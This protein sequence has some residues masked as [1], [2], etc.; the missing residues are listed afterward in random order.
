MCSTEAD[1][2]G[3]LRRLYER[4]LPSTQKVRI[5]D[6]VRIADGWETEVYSF[7]VEYEEAVR[8]SRLDL[9]LRI[10]PGD[11]A[12][13]KSAREFKAMRQLFQVGFPV[14][15]VLLLE[16]EG[17]HLGKPYVI[18]EKIEGR[19]MGDVIDESPD[20]RKMEL[21]TQ[22]CGMFV[23]LHTLD[24]RPF[25]PDP[26]LYETRELSAIFGAEL[27]GWRAYLHRFQ[28]EA[29]DPVF[30]WLGEQ[31]VG[32]RFGGPSVIHMDYHPWNILLRDD[33][34]AFV[35]DW[36]AVG[37]SDLRL[38]LAWT[39]LLMSTYGTPDAREMILGE[40]ERVAEYRVEQ[41]E[42]FDVV[43]SL[44]RLASIAVSLSEGAEKL[45]MRAGAEGMMQDLSHLTNV[46]GVLRDRSGIAIP[47]IEE[48]L[49]TLS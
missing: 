6:L 48:L 9:I 46:Y 7:A 49:A 33:G 23:D 16:S 47:A 19:P 42:F 13:E 37:V 28:M 27:E 44:R 35:I 26:S 22:F 18:M 5:V 32:V 4:E 3:E 14:P 31:I 38:D 25:V 8:Q 21:L 24:W 20:E 11:D 29:F 15:Q 1:V 36:G 41:I 10:Y 39:L 34:A 17:R 43:A 12:L 30:D 2:Q 40:Y 45:G